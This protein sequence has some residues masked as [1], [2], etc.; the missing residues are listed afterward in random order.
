M[1]PTAKK[2]NACYSINCNFKNMP[3]KCC[4]NQP[5]TIY[6][7]KLARIGMYK[8]LVFC[9]TGSRVVNLH[10]NM[11]TI[12]FGVLLNLP[13]CCVLKLKSRPYLH[14]DKTAVKAI[15]LF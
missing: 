3:Q 8:M 13:N 10:Y 15:T 4:K 9:N 6:I 2:N 11:I 12:C 14:A 1:R 7:L 5:T